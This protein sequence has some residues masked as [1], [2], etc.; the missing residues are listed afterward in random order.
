LVKPP[1]LAISFN[2]VHHML[3][4]QHIRLSDI[5][6]ASYRGGLGFESRPEIRLSWLWILI[7]FLGLSSKI[8][9]DAGHNC[10]VLHLS[11]FT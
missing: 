1:I 11:S 3:I 5:T 10:F 2:F 7:V 6:P 9:L 8:Q 4:Y